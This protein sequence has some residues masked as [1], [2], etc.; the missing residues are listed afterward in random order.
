M[1]EPKIVKLDEPLATDSGTIAELTIKEPTAGD[2]LK[3]DK[4]SGFEADVVAVATVTGILRPFIERLPANKVLEAAQII[5]NF[6][7]PSAPQTGA[8]P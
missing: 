5:G 3:W 7:S 8:L 1:A 6:I 2:L 4:L